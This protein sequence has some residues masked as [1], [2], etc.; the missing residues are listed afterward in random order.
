MS[1]LSSE[2]TACFLRKQGAWSMSLRTKCL[3]LKTFTADNLTDSN[4][5]GKYCYI[6]CNT[7]GGLG[8]RSVFS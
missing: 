2:K 7:G 6:G 5:E 3:Y 1:L 4:P 8:G